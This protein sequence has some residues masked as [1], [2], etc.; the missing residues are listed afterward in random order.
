MKVS[1]RGTGGAGERA[2]RAALWALYAFTAAAVGGYASFGTH[3]ELLARFP[4]AA[5]FYGVAFLFF[6]RVQIVLAGAALAAV[7]LPAVLVGPRAGERRTPPA[8]EALDVESPG[9]PVPVQAPKVITGPAYRI[10]GRRRLARLAEL[11]GERPPAAP[12]D[13][14]PA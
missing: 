14:W 9:L 8:E 5:G 3:P 4:G 7:G 10:T 12:A 6:S 1:E 11:V 13:A 2:A